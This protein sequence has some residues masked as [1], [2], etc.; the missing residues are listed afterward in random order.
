MNERI[1]N[2]PY[3]SAY[4][5]FDRVKG[6]DVNKRVVEHLIRAGALDCVDENRSKLLG[7][8]EDILDKMATSMRHQQEGQVGLF[9][10]LDQDFFTQTYWK[11]TIKK[12][13]NWNC[14]GMKKE[15]IGDY[16]SA[17]PLDGFLPQWKDRVALADLGESFD[18]ETVTVT[19]V[20]SNVA[21]R[22]TKTNRPFTMG[23]VEDFGKKITFLHLIRQNIKT[24]LHQ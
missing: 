18:K 22:T 6:R 21:H 17:H 5:F 1:Q 8:Y 19:G 20:L 16:L 13:L 11:S 24:S 14:C 4:D 12:S 7:V 3:K 9:Q 15:L 23:E 10:T 2:G